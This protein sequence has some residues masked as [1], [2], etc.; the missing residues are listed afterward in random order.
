MFLKGKIAINIQAQ[1][2]S[3]T[4]WHSLINEETSSMLELAGRKMQSPHHTGRR[5]S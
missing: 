3:E 5:E 1:K 4:V 2:V